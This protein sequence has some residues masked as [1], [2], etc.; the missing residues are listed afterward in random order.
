MAKATKAER[1]ARLN[2]IYSLLLAGATR[3]EI[4]QYTATEWNLKPRATDAY[5]AD[6]NA[7]IAQEGEYYRPREF[8][9]AI[10][11]L[12]DLYKR[13]MKVMDFKAALAVQR[14]LNGLLA[15]HEP[16]AP[17]A[18]RFEGL[19]DAL[20]QTVAQSLKA[21]QLDASVVFEAMIVELSEADE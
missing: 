5:I 4:L 13:A 14:E 15:L 19:D 6:A 16:A 18:F 9:R 1:E 20:L 21:K 11:R 8:G 10:A 17:Q 12:H 2:R 7:M 3:Y